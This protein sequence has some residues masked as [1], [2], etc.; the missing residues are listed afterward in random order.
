[1]SVTVWVPVEETAAVTEETEAPSTETS[2]T[3]AETAPAET[4]LTGDAVGISGISYR[5]AS[6]E[7][8]PGDQP[9]H[10]YTTKDAKAG[11]PVSMLYVGEMTESSDIMFGTWLSGF[12]GT[13]GATSAYGYSVGED[14]YASHERDTTLY[15]RVPVRLLT[16]ADL[17]GS[18]EQETTSAEA[19][20]EAAAA[21]E[22]GSAVLPTDAQTPDQ[23]TLPLSFLTEK[24]GLPESR[25]LLG[26]LRTPDYETP[27]VEQ[28]EVYED[29]A[30]A[31]A[32]AFQKRGVLAMVIG[33]AAAVIAAVGAVIRKKH[34][35]D[36][37]D[38]DNSGKTG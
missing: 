24:E 6:R 15:T 13:K 17:T 5:R 3:S 27:V 8:I 32:S 14:L 37:A 9:Y 25:L 2:S 18:G 16:A 29:T 35:P 31:Q 34:R 20:S 22:A 26:G 38:R 1:M 36:Q 30:H 23:R 21:P 10:L 12:F 28:Y 4:P 19:A 7:E 11:N 33:G